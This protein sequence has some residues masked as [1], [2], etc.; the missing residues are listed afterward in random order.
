MGQ[1]T[2]EA[3]LWIYLINATL[4]IVHE[5]DSAYWKE[6]ELFR[7]PGGISFFNLLH[8]PLIL[9]VLSGAML[10]NNANRSGFYFS[11]VLSAAGIFAF[12]VHAYFL[13]KGDAKFRSAVSICILCAILISSIIQAVATI[14]AFAQ[15]GF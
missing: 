15:P 9:L 5:I 11:A 6:W 12:F 13:K 7:I 3:L 2:H 8:I 1:T 4:I 10:I 14:Q